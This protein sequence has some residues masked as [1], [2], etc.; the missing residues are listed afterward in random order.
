LNDVQLLAR[1]GVA[2]LPDIGGVERVG[3]VLVEADAEGI[4]EAVGVDLIDKPGGVG[5]IGV[6]REGVALGHA[7]SAAGRA[8]VGVGIGVG[9][10]FDAEDLAVGIE[11]VLSIALSGPCSG[12]IGIAG[13]GVAVVERVVPAVVPAVARPTAAVAQGDVHVP[14]AAE[15]DPA[16]VVESAGLGDAQDFAPRRGRGVDGHDAVGIRRVD[17]P[18]ADDA[19]AVVAVGD[20]GLHRIA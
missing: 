8:G 20:A 4:A 17:G 15:G 6:E 7:I 3:V 16:A 18:F 14:I 1:E 10:G 9:G 13:I 2:V 11:S 5:G 12:R 19:L